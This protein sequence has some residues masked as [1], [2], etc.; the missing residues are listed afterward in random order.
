[1]FSFVIIAMVAWSL[2]GLFLPKPAD[3]FSRKEVAGYIKSKIQK[4][5]PTSVNALRTNNLANPYTPETT[6]RF[7]VH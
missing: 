6:W 2:L 4:N 1:M 3:L 7:V 5:Q